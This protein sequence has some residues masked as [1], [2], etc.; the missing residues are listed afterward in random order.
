MTSEHHSLLKNK[1]W[2]LYDLPPRKAPIGFEWVYKIKYKS[3]GSLDKYKACLVAKGFSQS[4]GIDYEETFAPTTKIST[5][6]L[7][8]SMA[9]QFG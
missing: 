1:T 9:A 7:V 8:L 6:R 3:D 4:Q 5:I 2:V